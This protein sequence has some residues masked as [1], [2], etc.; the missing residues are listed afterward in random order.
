MNGKKIG[1]L[2]L[3]M[4]V[5]SLL[6]A[7]GYS[8]P[9]RGVKTLLIRNVQYYPGDQGELSGEEIQKLIYS[10]LSP[11]FEVY[12]G[13][14]VDGKE[15]DLSLE[16]SLTRLGET[17]SVDTILLDREGKKVRGFLTGKSADEI[18]FLLEELAGNLTLLAYGEKT[19]P[20]RV[21]G[22]ATAAIFS[23]DE[24]K[25]AAP[26]RIALSLPRGKIR[27][28]PSFGGGYFKFSGGDV[29]YDGKHEIVAVGN[30]KISIIKV[31]E[32]LLSK[33]YTLELEKGEDVLYIGCGDINRD[34]S[35]E[36]IAT[37]SGKNSIRGLIIN[38]DGKGKKYSLTVIE[39]AYV[40]LHYDQNY[41]TVLV[42]QKVVS[43][44]TFGRIFSLNVLAGD[45]IQEKGAI[46]VEEGVSL[47]G[48]IP[49]W[50]NEKYH[51]IQFEGGELRFRGS[52]RESNYKLDGL[53]EEIRAVDLDGDGNQEVMVFLS[54][55]EK[56]GYF[57]SLPVKKGFAVEVYRISKSGIRKDYRFDNGL[58]RAGGFFPRFSSGG[59]IEEFIVIS[60]Q[61][62]DFFPS[63]IKWKEVTIR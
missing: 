36:V 51:V 35:A 41:G 19:G 2:P 26:S 52:G 40:R 37:V 42:S 4:L 61:G 23:T 1:M 50:F 62:N 18:P 16:V 30:G 31:Q 48:A 44:G 29:N 6:P 45:Q 22:P 20:S 24:Q 34:G 32:D 60:L 63:T 28:S 39:G 12:Q 54:M 46:D 11:S 38:Y 33:L 25:V 49:L 47:A 9:N 43:T 15:W 10:R 8:S 59:G 53:V 27:Y 58:L 13:E 3:L 21:G 17:I 14:M 55:V 5:L 57:E 56:S 7:E